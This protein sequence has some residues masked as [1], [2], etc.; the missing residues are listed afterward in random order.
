MD[1]TTERNAT[2]MKDTM[3][4]T[5]CSVLAFRTLHMGEWISATDIADEIR[6][7]L[8]EVTSTMERLINEGNK[9]EWKVVSGEGIKYK[10]HGVTTQ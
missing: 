1:L 7:P 6:Y 3:R 5:A 9:I 8:D 4:D 2:K 10:L